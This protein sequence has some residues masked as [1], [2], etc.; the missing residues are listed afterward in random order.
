GPNIDGSLSAVAMLV[1]R[2]LGAGDQLISGETRLPN[3]S[4][5]RPP[6]MVFW[7]VN[8]CTSLVGSGVVG[9]WVT[10]ASTP[11]VVSAVIGA[12]GL[13]ANGPVNTIENGPPLAPI[14]ATLPVSAGIVFSEFWTSTA[15]GLTPAM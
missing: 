11:P 15:V 5:N 13:P 2:T 3:W 8:R 6:L 12:T 4:W 10:S 1:A 14:T 7:N 9:F